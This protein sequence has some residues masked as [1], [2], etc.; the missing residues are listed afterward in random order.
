[1]EIEFAKHGKMN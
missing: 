1:L